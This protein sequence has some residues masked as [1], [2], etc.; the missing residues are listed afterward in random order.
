MG[1]PPPLEAEFARFSRYIVG[2]QGTRRLA[3]RYALAATR[4][5]L[6]GESGDEELLK[7][8]RRFPMLL[9]PLDAAAAFLRPSHLLRK[10]LL[11]ATAILEAT[12]EHASRF[13]PRHRS[14]PGF[15]FVGCVVAIV[16]ALR[17]A[18][19]VP[20]FLLLEDKQ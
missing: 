2:R 14:L 8:V 18:V 5:G 17:L 16:T 10:R 11:L 20:L 19:G 1:A 4:L 12:T 7:L 9:G 3:R 6:V 13:L 15:I